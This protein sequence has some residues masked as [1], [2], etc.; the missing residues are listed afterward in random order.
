[1]QKEHARNTQKE[2]VHAVMR[3]RRM[4]TPSFGAIHRR[5]TRTPS[6]STE[7]TTSSR[8]Y[9]LTSHLCD[10]RDGSRYLYVSNFLAFSQF[11]WRFRF[12][13]FSPNFWRFPRNRFLVFSPKSGSN[14]RTW[15]E[16]MR[17]I[18]VRCHGLHFDTSISKRNGSTFYFFRVHTSRGD[19]TP[20]RVRTDAK[21]IYPLKPFDT[22]I[23]KTKQ[24]DIDF[25]TVHTSHRNLLCVALV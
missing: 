22:A 11:F 13:A 21:Y 4:R 12:L 18:S 24:F 9:T 20:P 2:D 8:S 19:F 23:S 7:C 10:F 15:S 16:Q 1:M 3:R 5:R 17:N 25:F 14:I 6:S